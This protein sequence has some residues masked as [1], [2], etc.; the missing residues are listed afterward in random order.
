L[1]RAKITIVG[2]GNVGATAALWAAKREL[3]DIVLLDIPQT[4]DMPKGKAL[5]LYE[6]SPVELFDARVTGTNNYDDT[7]GSD[8]VVCTAGVPRK[9][10]PVTGQYTTRDELLAINAKIVKDVAENAAKRSPDS[11]MI[12]VSNPLDAMVYVAWKAS[13]FPTNRVVGQAGV[14]DTARFKAFVALELNVSVKDVTCMLMGGHGDDMVPLPR[15]SSVGGI[16]LTELLPKER[17]DAI[18]KRTQ[19]GGGEIVK[20][21]GT[22]S[23]YFAPGAA[24]AQMVESILRDQKRLIPCAAFCDQEYGVGGYFVGVPCVLGAGGVEKVL[25]LK[26][27]DAE[28]AAFAASTARVKDLCAKLKL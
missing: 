9:K 11:V 12:V 25:E 1:R 23:A 5:D 14:L 18:I 19:D 13:G 7:A 4:G 24:V 6:A 2:A 15:Y 26:L 3:G 22:G 10:D 16:P 21:L 27:N 28:R 8:V 17:L 20:L